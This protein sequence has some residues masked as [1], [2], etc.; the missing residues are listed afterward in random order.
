MSHKK[1]SKNQEYSDETDKKT[2]NITIT[3]IFFAC[4]HIP[5]SSMCKN[6]MRRMFICKVKNGSEVSDGELGVFFFPSR[7]IPHSLVFH[8]TDTHI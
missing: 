4:V 5:A 7:S 6:K 3:Q 1:H 2:N 8:R